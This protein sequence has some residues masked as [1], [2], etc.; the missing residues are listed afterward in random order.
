[1]QASKWLEIVAQG[2]DEDAWTG[3]TEAEQAAGAAV[4]TDAEDGS[5]RFKAWFE[6]GEKDAR[7][8]LNRLRS[9]LTRTFGEDAWLGSTWITES[10]WS[11]AWQR[12]WKPVR[13]GRFWVRPSFLPP[14][15]EGLIEIVLDPGM[16]F[17]TGTHP[18]TR[19]CLAAI[20]RVL[21]RRPN[22]RVLDMGAGSGILAIAAAKLGASQ[23][24]AVDCDPDAVEACRNNA[25][26][27]GVRIDC[28]L[29]DAPPEGP[30]ELVVANI[31][32]APLIAMAGRLSAACSDQLVLSGLLRIQRQ[33]VERAY[34]AQGF[35][36][37]EATSEEDWICLRMQA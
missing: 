16:A 35:R 27:N 3:W 5:R 33:E 14:A 1:M 36:T 11:T 4:E 23:V 31:L 24:V 2:I 15:P 10:D 21:G 25:R 26:A 37:V 8:L 7:A 29:G 6:A 22:P 13:V 32:A 30:F 18:T 34:E 9:S 28:R 12:Y 19:L 17:G 20:E